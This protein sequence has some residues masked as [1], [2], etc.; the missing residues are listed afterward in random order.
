MTP[1]PSKTRS[2]KSVSD[3]ILA[4]VLS[5]LEEDKAE[6]VVVIDLHGKSEMADHMVVCSGSLGAKRL[7]GR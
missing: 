1:N 3:D 6:D 4:R 2:N 7:E 5:S